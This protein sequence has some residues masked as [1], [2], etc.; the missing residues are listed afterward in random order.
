MALGDKIGAITDIPSNVG[1]HFWKCI[2][3]AV[4]EWNA[5]KRIQMD[6]RDY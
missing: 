2:K 6:G 1:E 5:E 3:A 4:P